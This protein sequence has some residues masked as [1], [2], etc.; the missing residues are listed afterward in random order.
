MPDLLRPGGQPPG[1]APNP[2]LASV[3]QAAH[4]LVHLRH[5]PDEDDEPID[6]TDHLQQPGNT[7]K[8]KVPLNMAG[9]P[10][11][12][13]HRGGEEGAEESPERGG[14]ADGRHAQRA[15]ST[16]GYLPSDSATARLSRKLSRVTLAGLRHKELL[17]TRKDQLVGVLSSVADSNPLAL[18]LALASNSPFLLTS[19]GEARIRPSRRRVAETGKDSQR[20]LPAPTTIRPSSGPTGEFTFV[21][22]SE[23][24]LF[25]HNPVHNSHDS[26]LLFIHSARAAFIPPGGGSSAS[27]L[28]RSGDE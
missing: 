23:S 27:K 4:S 20:T 3:T 26:F 2:D 22:L 13:D 6:Y 1:G 25:I 10:I 7:K 8:R 14:S 9:F 19:S 5:A 28:V 17:K 15:E 12:H 11:T 18:D 24:K 16:E 21:C